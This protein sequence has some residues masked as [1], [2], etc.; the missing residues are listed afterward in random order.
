MEIKGEV[1][2]LDDLIKVIREEVEAREASDG[3]KVTQG[4]TK[5]LLHNQSSS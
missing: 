4:L 2:K 3:T 1:W 5:P